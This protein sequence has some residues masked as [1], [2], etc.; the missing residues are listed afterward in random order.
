[1]LNGGCV[2]TNAVRRPIIAPHIAIVHQK[3][4]NNG[5]R[6]QIRLEVRPTGGSAAKRRR[7]LKRASVRF[8]F[9]ESPAF[10]AGSYFLSN[11][12]ARFEPSRREGS[13]RCLRLGYA[14]SGPCQLTLSSAAHRRAPCARPTGGGTSLKWAVYA[15][16]AMAANGFCSVAQ[17]NSGGR[18]QTMNAFKNAS[19]LSK[20]FN[21]EDRC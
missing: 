9:S 15:L 13:R 8:L 4:C 5:I 7:R 20:M 1:M 18:R 14:L 2:L 10:S 6:T 16:S 3:K 17:Q 12:A 11:C 21:F 19:V